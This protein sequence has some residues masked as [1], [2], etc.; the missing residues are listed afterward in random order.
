MARYPTKD[1]C[2]LDKDAIALRIDYNFLDNAL[3]VFKLAEY[4]GIKLIKYS[5][6]N[7]SELQS[8]TENYDIKDGFTIIRKCGNEWSFKTYYNDTLSLRRQRFTIAHEIK[9]VIY[10]ETNPTDKDED[11]ANHFAR[12]LLAPSCLVLLV[13]DKHTTSEICD[14]FN[15]SLDAAEN[16]VHA[17]KNRKRNKGIKLENYEKEFIDLIN[18]KNL[19]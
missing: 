8:I 6:M 11:L 3:D 16:S 1:Y 10:C 5:Q 18:K 2:K 15:I 7:P 9:H 4:L 13:M 14:I 17:N 19:T 12:V